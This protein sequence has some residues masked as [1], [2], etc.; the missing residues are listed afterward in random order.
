MAKEKV[1]TKDSVR[2]LGRRKA[3]A[4]RVRMEFSSNP[5]ITINNKTLAW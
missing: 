2:A 1:A 3:A 5:G 4:A